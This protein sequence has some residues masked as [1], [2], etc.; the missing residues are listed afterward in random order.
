MAGILPDDIE[1]RPD[2]GLLAGLAEMPAPGWQQ[3]MRPEVFLPEGAR[4]LGNVF[5]PALTS[6]LTTPAPPPSYEPNAAGKIPPLGYHPGEDAAGVELF[7]N[8]ATGFIPG[9]SAAKMAM[10]PLLPAAV[11]VAREFATP[12]LAMTKAARHGRAVEHGFAPGFWRGESTGAVPNEF[13]DGAWFSLDREVSGGHAA[14]GGVKERPFWLQ[15]DNVWQD[16]MP[17]TAD[18]YGR[19][20]EAAQQVNPELALD[21]A[22][23]VAPRR[24]VDWVIG[25]GKAQ[26]DFV[27]PIAP[28]LV[29]HV[30]ERGGA[31]H[32]DILSRAGFIGA[33]TE[34]DVH[35]FGGDGIR[36]DLAMFDPA[37]LKRIGIYLGLGGAAAPAIARQE[38]QG[39]DARLDG[40]LPSTP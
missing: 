33:G 15:L 37:H 40:L 39:V 16:S 24:G 4:A 34:R 22:K 25:F 18:K 26:P 19:V 3:Y 30:A 8:L 20:V 9:G 29:R 21:L 5:A 38:H 27:M 14:R 23:Q 12:G 11:K 32:A 17:M 31:N 1:Q 2:A 36:H 28:A 10:A 6:Y 7:A 35:M 13:P